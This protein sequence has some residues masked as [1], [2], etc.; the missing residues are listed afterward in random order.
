MYYGVD[1]TISQGDVTKLQTFLKQ[2]GYFTRSP[3]GYF[4]HITE[5]ALKAYQQDNQLI[6]T[7]I[8]GKVTRG[9]IKEES[10]SSAVGN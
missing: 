7:G 6:I 5:N 4:R 1:D 8:A 9:M 3:T 2:K 10:C